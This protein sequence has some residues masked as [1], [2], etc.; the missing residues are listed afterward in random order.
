MVLHHRQEIALSNV[1]NRQATHRH[2]LLP[3]CRHIVSNRPL[4]PR[5]FLITRERF[6]SLVLAR[7]FRLGGSYELQP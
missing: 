7:R 3:V 4:P 5:A 6:E 2:E 1:Q